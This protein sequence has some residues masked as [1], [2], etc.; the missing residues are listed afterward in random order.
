MATFPASHLV[1][2][3]TTAART[4]TMQAIVQR[5]YGGPD[6]FT[7]GTLPRPRIGDNDVLIRVERPLDL[8][9]DAQLVASVLSKKIAAGS[10]HLVLDIPI[11]P[12]AK[13]RSM[14]DAQRLRQ[15]HRVIKRRRPAQVAHYGGY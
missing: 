8:D 1:G 14:P 2:S 13:V 10:T 11:G 5:E 7:F 3:A 9:S 15:A 12:T 4:D 6:V